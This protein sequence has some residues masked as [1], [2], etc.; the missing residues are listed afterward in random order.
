MEKKE[1]KSS[2]NDSIPEEDAKFNDWYQSFR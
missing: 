1:K 2:S